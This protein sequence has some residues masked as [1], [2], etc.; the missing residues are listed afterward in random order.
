MPLFFFR[1]VKGTIVW[2][3]QT[4]IDWLTE[5]DEKKCYADLGRETGIRTP[6]QNNALHKG[7]ELIAK[8]LND[9]GL[10]MRKVIKPEIDIPWTTESAK[11]FLFTPVMEMMT[12]K[13]ST[14]KLAKTGEIEKIW[15]TLMRFLGEKHHIEYIP[16]PKKDEV[17][18]NYPQESNQTDF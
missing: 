4:A 3:T 10:D 12:G 11:K 18:I 15:D 7:C 6:T 14:T 16:F 13:K 9:A 1:P 17:K 8:A 2:E 5:N